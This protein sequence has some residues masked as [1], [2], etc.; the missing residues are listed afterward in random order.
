MGLEPL[1]QSQGVLTDAFHAQM[2]GLDA[3]DQEEGIERADDRPHVPQAF[4]PGLGDEGPRAHEVGQHRPV[5]VGVGRGE[6]GELA[7]GPVEAPAVDDDAPQG[8]AVAADVFRGTVDHDVSAMS[9]GIQQIGTRKGIVHNKRHPGLLG[10]G[11]D[12]L[13]VWQVQLGIAQ[14]LGIE[15][16][17]AGSDGLPEGLGITAVDKGGLDAQAGK[18][19]LEDVECSAVKIVAGYNMITR[20][21]N[22]GQRQGDGCH[23]RGR[24]PGR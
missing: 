20:L 7:I 22:G 4:Q 11:A 6:L 12:G 24:R 9:Q 19:I 10:D 3:L 21:Q 8:G 5:V 17:G 1:G 2:Q 23:A 15:G 18:G 13:E 16:P 14:S